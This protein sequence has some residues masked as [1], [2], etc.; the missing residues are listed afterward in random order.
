MDMVVTLE[1]EVKIEG[2]RTN[3]N[4]VFVA[5]RDAMSD[6]EGEV[7][8]LVIE[9]YQEQIV[10]TLCSP[11]GLVAKKG[12][13]GHEVKGQPSHRC[14]GRR[15]VRAGYWSDTRRLRGPQC[16]VDFR[17]AMVK[18]ERCGKRVTPILDALELDAYQQ[19]SDGLLR[20]VTESVAETSYRRGAAQLEV[21]GETPVPKSTGHRWVAEVELPVQQGRGFPVLGGDGTG[22]KRQPGERG[23]VRFVLEMGENGQIHPLG[24]WAGESW[25]EISKEVKDRLEGQPTLFVSDGEKAL[26]DWMGKLAGTH[27]RCHWHFSRD[28]SYA[29]WKDGAPLEE[30]KSS[31]ERLKRLVAIEIP[32]QS[33]EVVSEEDKK[34]LR[35]RI[36]TAEKQLEEMQEEFVERGYEK[37]AT[38][39]GNAK[40]QLFSHILLWLQTGLICPRTT[41]L[42]E[43]LIRELVRRL[44]KIGWN[45]SDQGAERMGRIVMI[46]RYD[47]VAWNDY[48]SRRMNLQG[49]CQ[50]ELVRV[51][52][53]RPP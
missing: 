36:E 30:R 52:T 46:R 7:T 20:L 1:L 24:V 23:E 13:G 53:N 8:Q 50:I 32:E 48:W 4:E 2:D 18:C 14:R 25:E 16:V 11:S 28:A 41:S 51:E 42:I 39:L 19:K 6:A 33:L 10:S 26:Q 34:E 9:A 5:V 49:R 27:G 35:T 31:T 15:F 38:Y 40:E 17:P 44:K 43:N 21:F 22:F 12:L 37:A 3:A 47:P 29:M 45:W